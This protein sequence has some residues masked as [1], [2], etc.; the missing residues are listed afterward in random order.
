M[1]KNH[2]I[3]VKVFTTLTDYVERTTHWREGGADR[4]EAKLALKDVGEVL[5]DIEW[6]EKGLAEWRDVALSNE[7]QARAAQATARIA[8]T[9][10]QSVLNKPRTHAEQQAADT[11]ARDWLV[12]I[13]SDPT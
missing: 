12:S 9:H 8:I 4:H 10:L 6:T 5:D 13:G 1:S 2:K 11:A 3:L 7:K